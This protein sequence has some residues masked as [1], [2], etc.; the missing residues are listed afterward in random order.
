M[1]LD[2]AMFHVIY[3]AS[4]ILLDAQLN[5]ASIEKELLVVI[6]T[7]DKFRAYLIRLKVIMY[8]DHFAIKYL[9]KKKYAKLRLIR[10]VLLL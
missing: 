5:Y 9:V 6:F 4:K 7:F 1:L 8:I 3:Y 10:L 2:E